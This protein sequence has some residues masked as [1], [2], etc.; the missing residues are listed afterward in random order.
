MGPV[1][2]LAVNEALNIGSALWANAENKKAVKRAFKYQ[3]AL[4]NQQNE[5]NK[6]INQ[7]ARYE[8][9][10]LNPNLIYGQ[11]N[12]SASASSVPQQHASSKPS[13]VDFSSAV[14]LGQDL[15]LGQAQIEQVQASNE[16]LA[17]QIEKTDAETAI[18]KH[19]LKITPSGV[20]TKDNSSL[21]KAAKFLK[22]RIDNTKMKGND[23][24][25]QWIIDGWSK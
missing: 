22:G 17:A 13:S 18:L 1:T 24:V 7:M 3:Q 9:A 15:K 4:I 10:G 19:E 20:S 12:L 14:K 11:A 25:T 16:L 21:G 23:D 6:P 8:E 5:Y 2:A